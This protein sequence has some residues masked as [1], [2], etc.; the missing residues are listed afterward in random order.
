MSG[1]KLLSY[2]NE[3]IVIFHCRQLIL[4][5][6][7]YNN[8][9]NIPYEKRPEVLKLLNIRQYCYEYISNETKEQLEILDQYPLKEYEVLYEVIGYK[10]R[11]YADS[12]N[13]IEN[14]RNSFQ[15]NLLLALL[16]LNVASLGSQAIFLK[17]DSADIDQ[18]L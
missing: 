6:F 2:E 18:G 17:E 9:V 13:K 15:G 7:S 14:T 3:N 12:F 10:I 5:I 11:L 16:A 1:Q 4:N 8:L